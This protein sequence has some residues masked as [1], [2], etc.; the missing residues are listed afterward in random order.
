MELVMAEYRETSYELAECIRDTCSAQYRRAEGIE[1]NAELI[2][3]GDSSQEETQREI[4]I[5]IQEDLKI[6]DMR[7]HELMCK[8]QRLQ[9]ELVTLRRRGV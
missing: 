3:T 9:T 6:C 1:Y 4:S 8:M 2:Y 7:E 5:R